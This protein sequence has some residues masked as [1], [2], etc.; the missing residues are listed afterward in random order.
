[1]AA[2]ALDPIRQEQIR[3][4]F[5]RNNGNIKAT[6]IECQVSEN[7]AS[8]YATTPGLTPAVESLDAMV[9]RLVAAKYAR[10][11]GDVPLPPPLVVP[12]GEQLLIEKRRSRI[13]RL[14]KE[15]K[16]VAVIGDLHIPFLD[17]TAFAVTM[18][19]LRDYKPDC[20]IVNGDIFDC[21]SASKYQQ[22]PERAEC[23]QDEFD[24]GK[25]IMQEIDDLGADTYVGEGNHDAR[26]QWLAI[27]KKST[28]KLRCLELKN[29]AEM[30]KRW[31]YHPSQY[32]F[33]ISSLSI[34]HGDLKGF[35]GGK[36][37]ASRMYER[38]KTSCLFG[39]FHR[40]QSHIDRTDNGVCRGG[41]ASPC[42]ANIEDVSEEYI[43]DPPW[44]NGLATIDIGWPHGTFSVSQ[45]L[46]TDGRLQVAGQTYTA[47]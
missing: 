43:T 3:A 12:I 41:W 13:V 29:A 9:E 38:L 19:F 11:A 31:S 18:N 16:R 30:P 33:R 10:L 34:L 21:Y 40:Q 25:P 46:I 20:V 24:T 2:P 36:Y 26:I 47:T 45:H 37:V 39:H 27:N 5:I 8:K 23:L 15:Y 44:A 6:A 17:L 28:H 35:G 1:M 4:A 42:L 14:D 32:R 7:T 22:S